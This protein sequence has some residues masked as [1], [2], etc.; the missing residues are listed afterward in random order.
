MKFNANR[1]H[2]TGETCAVTADCQTG[3]ICVSGTCK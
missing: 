3:K 2:I 1:A